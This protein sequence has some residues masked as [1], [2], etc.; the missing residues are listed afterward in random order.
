MFRTTIKQA[1]SLLNGKSIDINGL[2]ISVSLK[3]S[4]SGIRWL[5]KKHLK[6]VRAS[7]LTGKK[8]NERLICKIGNVN[9]FYDIEASTKRAIK[10]ILYFSSEKYDEKQKE[11]LVTRAVEDDFQNIKDWFKNKWHHEILKV[12]IKLGKKIIKSA[13]ADNIPSYCDKTEIV[14]TTVE[15]GLLGTKKF[16]GDKIQSMSQIYNLL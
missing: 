16:I 15:Q 13:Y 7:I 8:S 5:N 2:T 11:D 14:I 4:S 1:E 12:D 9:Y 10:T 3:R 6:I